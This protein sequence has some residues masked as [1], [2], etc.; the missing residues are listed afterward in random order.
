MRTLVLGASLALAVGATAAP[1][2]DHPERSAATAAVLN[3]DCLVTCT[4]S[5]CGVGQHKAYSTPQM[6]WDRLGHGSH[7]DCA[8]GNCG[9]QGIGNSA[10]DECIIA[11]TGKAARYDDLVGAVDRN[12]IPAVWRLIDR[13]PDVIEINW[14][15]SAIQ[16][17]GCQ[18]TVAINLPLTSEALAELKSLAH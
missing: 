5:A 12:D 8:A 7:S 17:V 18:G 11:L 1:V 13:N 4:Y 2:P 16:V 9:Y 15:R 14:A 3:G 6:M 10:H